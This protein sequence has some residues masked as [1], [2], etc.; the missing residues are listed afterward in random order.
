L[1]NKNKAFIFV[2]KFNTMKNTETTEP[3]D[4]IEWLKTQPKAAK[5]SPKGKQATG[6]LITKNEG[7]W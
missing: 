3:I 2:T 7:I 6:A 1:Q 4:W 5:E